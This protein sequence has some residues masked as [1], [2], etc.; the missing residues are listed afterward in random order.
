MLRGSKD[1]INTTRTA[2]CLESFVEDVR[3]YRIIAISKRIKILFIRDNIV[4]NRSYSVVIKNS[5][6][7]VTNECMYTLV[8][9]YYTFDDKLL[10]DEE[11]YNGIQYLREYRDFLFL[12]TVI[13][14]N[15]RKS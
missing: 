6:N 3:K 9:T 5:D 14:F 13:R 2:I 7:C 8:H 10:H 4:F 12:L 11:H 15:I 1:L